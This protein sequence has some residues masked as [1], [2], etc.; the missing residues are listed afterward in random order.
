MLLGIIRVIYLRTP[1]WLPGLIRLESWLLE[2]WFLSSAF[3]HFSLNSKFVGNAQNKPNNHV[4]DSSYSLHKSS[5]W[6]FT[7]CLFKISLI[8]RESRASSGKKNK[9]SHFVVVVQ[10]IHRLMHADISCTI[11]ARLFFFPLLGPES[12]LLTNVIPNNRQNPTPSWSYPWPT[13]TGSAAPS[14]PP[15]TGRPRRQGRIV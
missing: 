3:Y 8:S 2:S 14:R 11:T 13:T 5:L 15:R 10:L 6:V 4:N 1:D 7:H 12:W 9:F